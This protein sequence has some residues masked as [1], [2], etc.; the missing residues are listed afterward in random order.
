[1]LSVISA[2]SLLEPPFQSI[3]SSAMWD[4]SLFNFSPPP[5]GPKAIGRGIDL[6]QDDSHQ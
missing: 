5:C 2:V 1:M 3:Q 6:D 4:F